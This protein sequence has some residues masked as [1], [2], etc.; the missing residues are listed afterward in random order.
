MIFTGGQLGAPFRQELMNYVMGRPE[1]E[2]GDRLYE[3]VHLI[4]SSAQ[5]AV[6][7]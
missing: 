4:T 6:Q 2:V 5:Y 1:S 7:Q 3:L